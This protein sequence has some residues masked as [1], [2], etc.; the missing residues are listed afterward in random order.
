MCNGRLWF[1]T[2]VLACGVVAGPTASAQVIGT[3]RWQFAPFCNTVTL[4][5]EQKG[6]LYALTGFDDMCGGARRGGASG[7]ATSTPTAAC[8]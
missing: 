8:G 6:G 1:G 7:T 3:F 4:T 2:A 5:V